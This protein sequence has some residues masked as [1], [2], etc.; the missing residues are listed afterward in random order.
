[1]SDG[2]DGCWLG[3]SGWWGESWLVSTGPH[4]WVR[5]ICVLNQQEWRQLAAWEWYSC[6]R[7][8]T[9]WLVS[10]AV[11]RSSKFFVW[12]CWFK[13][14]SNSWT[15]VD[16]IA[17][18]RMNLNWTD[19]TECTKTVLTG[20]RQ[21]FICYGSLWNCPMVCLCPE[22]QTWPVETRNSSKTAMPWKWWNPWW[23]NTLMKDRPSFS[24]IFQEPPFHISMKVNPWPRTISLFR[25]L[26][27]DF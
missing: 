2:G 23:D 24:A 7:F 5:L 15:H 1:M 19:L 14:L 10:T 6:M 26:L 27:L 25:P 21:D 11:F 16:R 17:P 18:C 12:T 8:N 20:Q 13:C 22:Q 9:V 4:L 3:V